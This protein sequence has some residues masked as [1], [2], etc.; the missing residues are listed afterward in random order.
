VIDLHSLKDSGGQLLSRSWRV[1][2]IG[3]P[4]APAL[5]VDLPSIKLAYPPG[6][7]PS[8][9]RLPGNGH[10]LLCRQSRI[11]PLEVVEN[12]A[13][14]GRDWPAGFGQIDDL[15]CVIDELA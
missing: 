3:D 6:N 11:E 1:A 7:G 9:R 12:T 15:D 13:G 10:S 8:Q 5:P 4:S 14:N 2:A